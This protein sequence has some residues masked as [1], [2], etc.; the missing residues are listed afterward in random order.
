M[1]LPMEIKIW[2]LIPRE[3]NASFRPELLL[4]KIVPSQAFLSPQTPDASPVHV[5][6]ITSPSQI[7]QKLLIIFAI[8]NIKTPKI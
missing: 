6:P 8:V 4:P 2:F 5:L 7:R 3:K 1:S